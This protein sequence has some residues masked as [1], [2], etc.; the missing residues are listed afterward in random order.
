M[1]LSTFATV[2]GMLELLIGIPL[3][4]F[5]EE[6]GRWI[7]KA[8]KEDV[9]IRVIGSILFILGGLVIFEDPR[10]DLNLEGFLRLVAWCTAIKG[11]FYAWHPDWVTS[12]KTPWLKDHNTCLLLGVLMNA[13]GFLFISAASVM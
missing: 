11:V 10:I 7:V 9:D 8:M 5:P 2:I 12:M 6:S 4:V 1:D 13:F 3:M